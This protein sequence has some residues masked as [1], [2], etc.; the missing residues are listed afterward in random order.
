MSF[1]SAIVPALM[2]N[3]ASTAQGEDEDLWY[4]LDQTIGLVILV[5][6]LISAVVCFGWLIWKAFGQK[7]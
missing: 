1:N 5:L 4:D 2:L 3:S 7:L 6:P